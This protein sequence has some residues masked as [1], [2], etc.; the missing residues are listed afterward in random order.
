MKVVKGP[1]P[2]FLGKGL[3]GIER[4]VRLAEA[5]A[6]PGA[7]QRSHDQVEAVFRQARQP[8]LG[9]GETPRL[10]VFDDHHQFGNRGLGIHGDDAAGQGRGF[11]HAAV[12]GHQHEG[13]AQQ[14]RRVGG[15]FQRRAEEIGGRRQVAPGLGMAPGE[16]I[17]GQRRGGIDGVFRGRRFRAVGTVGRAGRRQQHRQQRRHRGRGGAAQRRLHRQSSQ[18]RCQASHSLIPTMPSSRPATVGQVYT[19]TLNLNRRYA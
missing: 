5:D 10:D 13:P 4:R 2:I 14:V 15:L 9:L 7:E 12:H 6:R 16:I 8:L 3:E 18:I 17:P 11:L 19:S 1:R